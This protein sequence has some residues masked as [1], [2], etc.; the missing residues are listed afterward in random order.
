MTFVGCS[1]YRQNQQSAD[2]PEGRAADID[3]RKDFAS[4]FA[5]CC[6]CDYL[7]AWAVDFQR[8]LGASFALASPDTVAYKKQTMLL[9]PLANQ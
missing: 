9:L 7:R 6:D 8:G 1:A 3:G 2:P 4:A 5:S